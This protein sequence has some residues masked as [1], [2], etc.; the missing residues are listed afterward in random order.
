M[1]APA[2]GVRV[3]RARDPRRSRAGGVLGLA[4]GTRTGPPP[5]RR[6]GELC[7]D[8]DPVA[9]GRAV[10]ALPRI[11]QVIPTI[12]ERDAVSTHT[13]EAQRVLHDL[14]VESDIYA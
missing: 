12:V 11:D 13:L 5:V 3:R 6:A 2:R 7:R 14:G 1:A 9:L 4:G 8:R 10:P